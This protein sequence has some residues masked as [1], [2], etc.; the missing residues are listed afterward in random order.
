[1]HEKEKPSYTP[2]LV[3]FNIGKYSAFNLKDQHSKVLF[4]LLNVD[5]PKNGYKSPIFC[6]YPKYI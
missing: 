1:M 5:L 4:A 3:L 2:L 6:A